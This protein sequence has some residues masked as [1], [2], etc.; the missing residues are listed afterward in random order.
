MKIHY[1]HIL[2]KIIYLKPI[3]FQI[4]HGKRLGIFLESK[5][6]LFIHIE[7]VLLFSLL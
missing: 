7:N 5:L 2:S 1:S 6:N 3:A 4:Q